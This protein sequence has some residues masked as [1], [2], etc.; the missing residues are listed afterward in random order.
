M[1]RISAAD[2]EANK[3]AYDALI[4]EIF[5]TEGWENVTY[6]RLSKDLNVRKSTLQGYY[7]TSKHFGTAI[8]GKVLPMLMQQ[9]DITSKE[10]FIKTWNDALYSKQFNMIIRMFVQ[11]ALSPDTNAGARQGINNLTRLLSEHMER[12]EA[13]AVIKTVLGDSVIVFMNQ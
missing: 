8:H 11:S 10:G 7:P 13:E 12:S 4:F 6:D 9:L 5:T 1:A 3:R 2:R